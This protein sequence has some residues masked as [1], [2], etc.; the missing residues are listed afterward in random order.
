MRRCGVAYV[1]RLSREFTTALR[2]GT[3]SRTGCGTPSLWL[4]PEF[5]ALRTGYLTWKRSHAEGAWLN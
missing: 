5:A 2:G 1:R 3:R 4:L